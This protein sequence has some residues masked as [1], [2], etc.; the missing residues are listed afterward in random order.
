MM[1]AP[2]RTGP[3]PSPQRLLPLLVAVVVAAIGLTVLALLPAR[4]VLIPRVIAEESRYCIPVDALAVAQHD[5]AFGDTHHVLLARLFD[6][7]LKAVWQS[8]YFTQEVTPS[9]AVDVNGDGAEEL[10]LFAGDSTAAFAWALGADGGEVVRLGPLRDTSERAGVPWGGGLS[11]EGVLEREGRRKLLCRLFAGFSRRPR[12]ITLFDAVTREREWTFDMGAFPLRALTAD[13]DGDGA[14]E[15]VVTTGSPDNGVSRNGTDDSHC[16]VVVIGAG[17]AREWQVTM[18]GAFGQSFAAVL[19]PYGDASA[20]RVVATF[21]SR[22]ARQPEP[23]RILL[24]DGRNGRALDHHE[25]PEGLGM[26][27]LLGEGDAFVVGSDDGYL[28]VFERGLTRTHQ[29]RVG[30]SVE[31]WGCVDLDEDGEAEIVASTPGEVLVLEQD[32]S[33]RARLPVNARNVP[34]VV[35][36]ASAGVGHARLAVADGRALAVDVAVR[37][38][39]R[40]ASSV[41]PVLG[42]GL[43]SGLAVPFVLRLRRARRR[44]SG[45]AAREFLLDYHQIRHETFERERP[46]ARLRLWAQ[47]RAAGHPL[48]EEMLDSACEEFERIGLPTLMRFAERAAGIQVEGARV[49]SI[50]ARAREIRT[51]LEQACIAHGDTRAARVGEALAAIDVLAQDCYEAYWEVVMRAPCRANQVTGEAMLAKTLQL[52]QARILIRYEAEPGGREPILFDRDELRALMGELI[53]NAAR[54]LDGAPDALLDVSIK[55]HATDPRRIV[56]TVRDNGS[57]LSPAQREALFTPEALSR[58]GGGFGLYH[59][60]EV[61]HRWLADLTV[62]EPPDGRGLAIRLVVRACR[63]LDRVRREPGARGGSA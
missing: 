36:L 43:A 25:F 42:L 55:E 17:G 7:Q 33:I 13:V 22:R 2:S 50:R 18:G 5:F 62:E 38:Y 10:C 31:A 46:F 41:G 32:L 24:L 49:R 57:G 14:S 4:L 15:V 39:L 12:G 37:P 35:R 20:P 60:R 44:P 47:A 23:G 27:R 19:P 59:A 26:P 63:V 8:N 48:P 56:I 21:S 16:Y 9:A 34:A 30:E 40:S 29:R 6:G 58:E 53:Q 45:A 11:I 61:A 28:R 52:E 3:P 1:N 54:A 51:A